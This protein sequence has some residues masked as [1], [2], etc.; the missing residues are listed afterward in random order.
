MMSLP[1]DNLGTHSLKLI[2]IRASGNT[3]TAACARR[4]CAFDRAQRG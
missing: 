1:R 3:P 4:D 2:A